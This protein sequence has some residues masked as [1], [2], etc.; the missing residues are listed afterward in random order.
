MFIYVFISLFVLLSTFCLKK[1]CCLIM[2]CNICEFLKNIKS[3]SVTV[4][5][6]YCKKGQP[7]RGT[8][9]SNSCKMPV[10]QLKRYGQQQKSYFNI[11]TLQNVFTF[12]KSAEMCLIF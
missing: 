10:K 7:G 5:D 8:F 3:L 2:F 6:R 4:T 12:S 9:Y 11:K 1:T